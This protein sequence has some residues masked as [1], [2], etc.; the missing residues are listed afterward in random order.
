VLVF[1]ILLGGRAK[2]LALVTF[3]MVALME[4]HH[5][6][7]TIAAARYTPGL[8]TAIPYIALGVLFLRALIRESKDEPIGAFAKAN[9][10][11]PGAVA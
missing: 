10:P 5:V 7:E 6:M 9:R 4:L 11:L 2:F 8:V 1:S 3:N